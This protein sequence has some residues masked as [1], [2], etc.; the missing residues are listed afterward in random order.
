MAHRVWLLVAGGLSL[1]YGFVF[2]RFTFTFFP[3]Y[4]DADVYASSAIGIACLASWTVLECIA[5]SRQRQSPRCGCGYSLKGVK[6]PECGNSLG[7]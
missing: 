4:G 3:T 7:E 1:A 5:S 2:I 6:C